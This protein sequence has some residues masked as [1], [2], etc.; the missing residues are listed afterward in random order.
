MFIMYTLF[1]NFSPTCEKKYIIKIEV[2]FVRYL[3]NGPD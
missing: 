1:T 3:Y 2:H